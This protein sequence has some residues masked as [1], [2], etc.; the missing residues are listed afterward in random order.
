MPGERASVRVAD[1]DGSFGRC[2]GGHLADTPT[3]TRPITPP[4]T[5]PTRP[6]PHSARTPAATL[7]DTPTATWPIPP[8]PTR[9][10]RP[11]GTRRRHP[12]PLGRHT[13]GHLAHT[14]TGHS[15]RPAPRL[16]RRRHPRPLGRRLR[17]HLAGSRGATR[18][19]DVA[20]GSARHR[21]PGRADAAPHDRPGETVGPPGGLRTGNGPAD[22]PRHVRAGSS[23]PG[24]AHR[25]PGRTGATS[26]RRGGMRVCAPAPAPRE[27]DRE[28]IRCARQ[29]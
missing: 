22:R 15:G 16:T 4:A 8:P 11:R 19:H 14:A 3:A 12:R 28:G 1:R 9:P 18:R 23:P 21:S 2:A 25:N 6:A 26:S 29:E 20:E 27:P 17:G 10:T 7:A 5:R 24:L 13:H